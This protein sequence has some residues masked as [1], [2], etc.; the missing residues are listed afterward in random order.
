MS[1][2]AYLCLA[3]VGLVAAEA[4]Q[5]GYSPKYNLKTYGNPSGPL[6]GGNGLQ[7]NNGAGYPLNSLAGYGYGSYANN[8]HG[9]GSPLHFGSHD[10]YNNYGTKGGFPGYGF[11]NGRSLNVLGGYGNNGVYGNGFK[12]YG[13]GQRLGGYGGYNNLISSGAFGIGRVNGYGSYG[14]GGINGYG[15]YGM[16]GLS[17]YR[18]HGFG[19]FR[20]QKYGYSGVGKFGGKKGTY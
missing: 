20:N 1:L 16:G 6:F 14:I 11:M 15:A 17:G 12:G 2:K 10:G 19:G 13:F 18:S 4:G 8:F 3:L 9:L 7:G 5:K